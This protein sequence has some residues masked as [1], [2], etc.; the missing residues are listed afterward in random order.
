LPW[1]EDHTWRT[2]EEHPKEH[3]LPPQSRTVA[4]IP[5]LLESLNLR[6]RLLTPYHL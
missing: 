5:N 1:R 4:A 6:H 2:A 3:S